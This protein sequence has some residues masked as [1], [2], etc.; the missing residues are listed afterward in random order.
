MTNRKRKLPVTALVVG[1]GAVENAWTPVFRALQPYFDFPLTA[2][3]ANCFLARAV[4]LL[5][6]YSSSPGELA[7]QPL[8][9]HKTFFDKVKKAICAEIQASQQRRELKVRA[10]FEAIIDL[11]LLAHS[12]TFML[13]TTNW[14]TVVPDSRRRR[15]PLCTSLSDR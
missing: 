11:L 15:A 4:Y 5:R 6:W 14:D 10:E 13:V 1:A 7:K 2:D 3:G 9:L 12:N 8:T